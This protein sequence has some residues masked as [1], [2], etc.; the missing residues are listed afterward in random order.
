[1]PLTFTDPDMSSHRKTHNA[2][3][4]ADEEARRAK[5]QRMLDRDEATYRAREEVAR[6]EAAARAVQKR[7]RLATE[8][9]EGKKKKKGDEGRSM[10]RMFSLLAGGK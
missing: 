8:R 6:K 4:T 2:E 3:R 10:K 1:M 9:E 5:K 7:V